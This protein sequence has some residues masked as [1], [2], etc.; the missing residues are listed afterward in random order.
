MISSTVV[1]RPPSATSPHPPSDLSNPNPQRR[2]ALS[3]PAR[4]HLDLTD[5]A[6]LKNKGEDKR[7]TN[8][9]TCDPGDREGQARLKIESKD[10]MGVTAEGKM[11]ELKKRDG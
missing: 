3:Y 10:R 11:Y 6:D 8:G 9:G 2:G 1:L 7:T 4:P 5:V